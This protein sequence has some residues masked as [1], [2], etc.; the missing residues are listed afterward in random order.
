MINHK[1]AQKKAKQI[2]N[3]IRTILLANWD[4]IGVSGIPEAQDEYDS[5]IGKIYGVLSRTP[6]EEK[7]IEILCQIETEYMELECNKEGLRSVA[8]KLLKI[9]TSLD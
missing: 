6:S 4:P 5:Y 1:K 3:K 8:R 7:L 9:D 2:Q